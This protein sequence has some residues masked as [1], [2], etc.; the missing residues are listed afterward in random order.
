MKF[1]DLFDTYYFLI[2]FC[3]GLFAVYLTTPMPEIYIKY[4]TPDNAH[5]LVYKDKVDVCYQYIPEE[6]TCPKDENK[7]VPL[8]ASENV[9]TISFLGHKF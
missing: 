7:I 2:A 9:N 1:N 4:P 3:V 6:T 8:M 5:S